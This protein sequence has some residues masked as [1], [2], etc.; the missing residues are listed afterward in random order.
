MK[1]RRKVTSIRIDFS[2]FANIALLLIAFFV[3]QKIQEQQNVMGVRDIQGCR[4]GIE[5][6]RSKSALKI[7]LLD[8]E[9]IQLYHYPSI[10]VT[11]KSPVLIKKHS[12]QLRALLLPYRKAASTSGELTIVIA[13]KA[14]STLGTF[15]YVLNELKIAG[16]LP[17]LIAY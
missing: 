6:D 17:Y 14:A 1:T 15:A 10:S 16:N 5:P 3:W 2:P 13:P 9:R 11:Q 12:S 8:G 4:K 7:L